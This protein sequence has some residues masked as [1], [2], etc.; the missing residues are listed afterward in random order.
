MG[1]FDKLFKKVTEPVIEPLYVADSDIVAPADGK[2]IDVKTVPDPVFAEEM[3]GKT[4]AFKFDGD[5][6]AVCA[7]A[8]GTLKVMF[9]TGHAFGI[10]T[11]EGVE[12]LI[13]IGIDTVNANGDGFKICGKKQGDKVKAG[14]PIVKVDMKKLSEKY[15]TSTMLIITN[16]NKKEISFIDSQPVTRGSSLLK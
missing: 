3:M 12:I 10:E 9:P 2:I 16:D 15:D 4:I 5:S 7:P 11:A 8:N 6:V 1:L 14:E 13:H